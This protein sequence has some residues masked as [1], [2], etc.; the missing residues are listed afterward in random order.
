MQKWEYKMILSDNFHSTPMKAPEISQI[1]EGTKIFMSRDE[2]IWSK[3]LE[4]GNEGWE[5]I[6]AFPSS[7]DGSTHKVAFIFKRPIE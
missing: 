7:W 6:N 3:V 4:L 2:P 1:I 5:L